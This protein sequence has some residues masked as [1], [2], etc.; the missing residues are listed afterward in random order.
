MPVSNPLVASPW[1]APP[2]RFSWTTPRG[3]VA[4]PRF[5]K[6]SQPLTER[7]GKTDFDAGWTLIRPVISKILAF[8]SRGVPRVDQFRSCVRVYPKRG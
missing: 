7:M 4:L 6:N 2:G 5:F 3:H 8:F 1:A